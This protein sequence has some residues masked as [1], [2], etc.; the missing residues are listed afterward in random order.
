M[1]SPLGTEPPGASH[2]DERE[3]LSWNPLRSV[4][5]DWARWRTAPWKA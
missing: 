5:N 4:R 2:R 3:D 1:I